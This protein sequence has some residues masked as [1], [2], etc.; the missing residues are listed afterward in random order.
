MSDY[1]LR[2]LTDRLEAKARLGQALAPHHRVVYVAAGRAVLRA[3]GQAAALA[4][5]SA[6]HGRGALDIE[7]GAQGAH[8]LRFELVRSPQPD[9]GIAVG[10]GVAS[11]MT[12]DAK[13]SLDSG[14]GYL[15]RCDKVALPPG[16]IAHTHTHQGPGIRCLLAGGF[17]VETGGTRT[18]I[19]PFEAWFEAGPEPVRAWAPDDLPGVFAR[20]MILPRA[21]KGAS[22]IR[23]VDAAD[24]DRPKP[25]KYIVYI[26]EILDF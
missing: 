1:V 25:Q 13:L 2:L 12:L 8:L 4:A 17:T 11:S 20:V 6:W 9:D 26:D 23:Y 16:G 24:A 15:M 5:D 21:L 7:A 18:N 3:G 10:E 19:A 22:S 14:D